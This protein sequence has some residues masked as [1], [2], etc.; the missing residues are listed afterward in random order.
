[1]NR[2]WIIIK[3]KNSLFN[4]DVISIALA[5]EMLIIKKNKSNK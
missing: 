3:N 5:I 4:A 2:L 1:M